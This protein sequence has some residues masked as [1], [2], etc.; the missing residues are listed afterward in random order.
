MPA[1]LDAASGEQRKAA[2]SLLDAATARLE[3]YTRR[4]AEDGGSSGGSNS[5]APGAPRVE[6]GCLEE[7]LV[8]QTSL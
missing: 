3:K 1:Q 6:V 4:L 2:K 7:V 5:G 8:G